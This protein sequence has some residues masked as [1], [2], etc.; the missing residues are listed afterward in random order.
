[1]P[2]GETHQYVCGKIIYVSDIVSLAIY[3]HYLWYEYPQLGRR[4]RS[5]ANVTKLLVNRIHATYQIHQDDSAPP[6]LQEISN[7]RRL[8]FSYRLNNV[9]LL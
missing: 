2:T 8:L 6:T 5:N 4:Y 7:H 3:V 1:M 9:R